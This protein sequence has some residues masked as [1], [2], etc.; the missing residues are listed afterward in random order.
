MEVNERIQSLIG[1]GSVL[2]YGL[3]IFAYLDEEGGERVGYVS[4]EDPGVQQALGM[5]TMAT[6]NIADNGI[7]QA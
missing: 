4:V 7:E 6:H 1:E 3:L 5:L 2:L